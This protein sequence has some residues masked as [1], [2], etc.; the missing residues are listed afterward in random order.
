MKT[1]NQLQ[2]RPVCVSDAPALLEIYR[3]IVEQTSTSFEEVCPTLE[4]FS[5]RIEAVQRDH[6]WLVATVQGGLSGYAY[7]TALKSRAAYRFSVETTVYVHPEKHQQHLGTA[8]YE[9]LF[10]KLQ[11]SGFYNAFALITLPNPASVA[12]HEKLGFQPAGLLPRAGFKFGQW[13]DVGWW[14]RPLLPGHPEPDGL[15]I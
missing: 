1:S 11:H 9:A 6:C 4:E 8:L 2:I 12:F 7:A 5:K 10:E 13:H 14:Y 15:R 3:P